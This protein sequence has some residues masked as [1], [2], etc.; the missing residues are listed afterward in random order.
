M[1]TFHQKTL[2]EILKKNSVPAIGCTEP[3]AVAYAVAVAR[4]RIKK[5]SL[6]I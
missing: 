3:I 2:V 4:K 1:V 5:A 6:N